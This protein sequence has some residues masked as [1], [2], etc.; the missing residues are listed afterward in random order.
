M[1]GL[2]HDTISK[3]KKIEALA[4]AEQ[5]KKIQTGKRSIKSVYDEIKTFEKRKEYRVLPL[6]KGKYRVLYCDPPWPYM[7][8]LPN[9]Y[10]DAGKHY[11]AMTLQEICDLPVKDLGAKNSALFLWVT[12]PMLM[13]AKDVIDAWG[14]VYKS[15][16]VWDKVKHN[17]GFYNSVRHEHLLICTRGSCMPDSRKLFDSVISIER[18]KRHSEKPEYFR[19][20]IDLLYP[21][22]EK[23][24]DRIELF[25]RG[26]VPRWWAA[27]G[28]EIEQEEKVS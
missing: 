22:N 23:G 16:F 6:P 9:N 3:V 11:P 17:F 24:I 18:S 25:S 7:K 5:K 19:E 20:L 12:S 21:P 8:I 13:L 28:N 2:S 14:Y 4:T 15:S 27:W 1:V 26:S 10:G